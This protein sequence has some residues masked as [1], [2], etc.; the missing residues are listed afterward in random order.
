[1][2]NGAPN[3]P[4]LFFVLIYG[5][6]APFWILSTQIAHS[7]LPDNLPLTDIGAVLTPT[8]AAAILR[9]REAGA[10]GVRELFS[11]TFDYS[12]IPSMR[13][14]I[15]AVVVF[16]LLYLVTYLAMRT[17]DYPVPALWN[18]SLSLIG[19]FLLF[20]VAAAAEE[21]GYTAYETDALQR[22]MNA[23]NAALVMGPLWALWHLPSMVT[24]GQTKELIL[25]GLC[26]TVAI[27]ILSVWIYNNAGTSAFAIILMHTIANTAR[28]GFP[29][30]RVSYELGNGSIPYSIIIAFTVLVVIVWRPSTLADFMGCAING[31]W[32]QTLH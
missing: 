27:R 10:F 23:L 20:F 7:V 2:K 32:R 22:R 29:G 5:L 11:R 1:M 25:W 30:G 31:K 3:N 15:T 4:W 17:M 13:W 8:V 26:V 6:S 24:M 18:P 9:Y 12:R 28:T 19:V 14:F 21:L 16:P